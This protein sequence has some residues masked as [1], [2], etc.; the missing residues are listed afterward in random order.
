ML[1]LHRVG[2][3]GQEGHQILDLL[4]ELLLVQCAG[5]RQYR[6]LI[7]RFMSQRRT[8]Q[9]IELLL[10]VFDDLNLFAAYDLT[11]LQP[12]QNVRHTDIRE[13]LVVHTPRARRIF[14]ERT[15]VA[16]EPVSTTNASH[17][18]QVGRSRTE[19]GFCVSRLHASAHVVT[20]L[21]ASEHQ[22]LE[23]QIMRNTQIVGDALIALELGTVA[24]HA[25]VGERTRAI[26]HCS[27]VGDVDID[28]FQLRTTMLGREGQYRHSSKNQYSK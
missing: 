6:Q 9:R 14:V 8:S 25:V 22:V 15:Q 26:L 13:Y 1:Q 24:P 11:A 2:R 10:A 16:V 17:Q 7:A 12:R 5:F 28:L 3:I 4:V 21:G 23:H 19:P 18:G 20:D 27:L